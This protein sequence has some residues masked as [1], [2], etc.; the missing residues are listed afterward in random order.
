MAEQ[1]FTSHLQQ[2]VGKP[3]TLWTRSG[4]RHKGTLVET[5]QDY[6]VIQ[7]EQMTSLIVPLLSVDAISG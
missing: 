1:S 4:E 3:V 2:L 7:R 6:L 5:G